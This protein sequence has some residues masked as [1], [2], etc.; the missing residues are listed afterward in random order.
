MKSLILFLFLVGCQSKPNLP[1]KYDL[2]PPKA[3]LF[4]VSEDYY[5]KYLKGKLAGQS[6][7][8]VR[9]ANKYKINPKLLIAI[10]YWETGNG[11]FVWNNNVF[12]TMR[13]TRKGYKLKT[14]DSV[15]KSIEY[16]ARSLSQNYF[17]RGRRTVEDIASKYC[18]EKSG[19]WAAGVNSIIKKLK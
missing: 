9:A 11:K 15:Q 2:S 1:Q 17:M 8:F 5:N 10:S 16:T 7:L 14:F 18:P 12:G 19:K 3:E 13:K 6:A 4:P